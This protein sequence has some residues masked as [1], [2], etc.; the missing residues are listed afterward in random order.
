MALGDHVLEFRTV[1]LVRVAVGAQA[2]EFICKHILRALCPTDIL[3]QIFGSRH[4]RI[5]KIVV[6]EKRTV[7]TVRAIGFANEEF[8]T[9]NFI[10]IQDLV[11]RFI[12][13]IKNRF[14]VLIEARLAGRKQARKAGLR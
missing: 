1:A 6:G 4:A 13:M 14:Y 9:S 11:S 8:Q 10:R 3:W 7:M 12:I 2:V 5:M